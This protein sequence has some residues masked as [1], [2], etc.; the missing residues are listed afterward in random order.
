MEQIQSLKEGGAFF[1]WQN[2]EQASFKGQPRDAPYINISIY[3]HSM[4]TLF[5]KLKIYILKMLK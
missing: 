4:I 5:N 1:F 2:V 3:L